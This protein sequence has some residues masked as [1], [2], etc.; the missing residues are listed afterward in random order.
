MWKNTFFLVL[1]LLFVS[2]SSCRRLIQTY[3]FNRNMYMKRTHTKRNV[4]QLSI[5]GSDPKFRQK[6]YILSCCTT[7]FLF[8]RLFP[9]SSLYSSTCFVFYEHYHN[10]FTFFHCARTHTQIFRI[11]TAIVLRRQLDYSKSSFRQ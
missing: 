8:S 11:E 3:T 7:F 2:S 10:R 6:R 1:H 5:V 9:C 4:C